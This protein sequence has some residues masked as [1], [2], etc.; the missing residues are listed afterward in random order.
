MMEQLYLIA[1]VAGQR[2]A[3]RSAD[4]ESVVVVRNTTKVPAAPPHI[5]GLFAL[6]SRVITLVDANV[7]VGGSPHDDA[8]GRKAIIYEHDGHSY[9]IIVE[10]V[11]DVLFI[12]REERPI[13]GHLEAGWSQIADTML[14]FDDDTLLVVNTDK[15]VQGSARLKAA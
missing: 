13:R 7:S 4:V 2:T 11:E 6:R 9:G 1:K 3:F 8:E 10:Q 15:I 12:D 14:D 5:M